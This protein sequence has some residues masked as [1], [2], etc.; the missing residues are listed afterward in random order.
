MLEVILTLLMISI[1]VYAI[2]KKF[3]AATAIFAVS[4][5][6]LVLWTLIT[7]NS[8]QG[9][10][11]VGNI[12]LDVFEFLH[13]TMQTQMAGNVLVVM[14]I[15]GYVGF[16]NHLKASEA[17]TILVSRPLQKISNPYLLAGMLIIVGASL[18]LV[19]PSAMAT[20]SL[21]FAVLYPALL[22]CGVTKATIA[23][24]LVCSTII[25]WGPADAGVVM[26]AAIVAPEMSVTDF[27]IG[28][29]FPI[30]VSG[31]IAMAITFFFTSRFFDIKENALGLDDKELKSNTIEDLGIPKFYAL[32]P[33]L[34]LIF[35]VLFSGRVL[36]FTM[37][38][39]AAA[40]LS[41]ITAFMIH[42]VTNIKSLKSAFNDITGFYNA[43]G[44]YTAKVAFIIIA[45][46]VFSASLNRVGGMD[47]IVESLTNM[48]G[49]V[50]LLTIVGSIVAVVVTASTVSYM[51][52]LNVFVPF[53]L[54]IS[55][56]TGFNAATLGG[57]ANSAT[58]LGT[59]LTPASGAMLFISGSC[60]V[61]PTTI[62]KRNVIP[63]VFALIAMIIATF[64]F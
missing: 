19:I 35:I 36:P 47:V 23:S 15:M 53:F 61:S 31:L 40:L 2:I 52:N 60:G 17:F 24:G 50:L 29:H 49:G 43:M 45:G 32:L 22:R 4:I 16:M 8:L 9:E 6:A 44:D 62:I 51:A 38:T 58:G 30:A 7:G 64:V 48:G 55:N 34:P 20:V 37:S 14:V 57:I 1:V 11:T 5:T 33:S 41:L 42:I 21:L 12:F 27:F 3:H 13:A 10:E 25:T 59:G 56:V 46:T 54:S 18:K 63:I 28:Y 39:V 26:T